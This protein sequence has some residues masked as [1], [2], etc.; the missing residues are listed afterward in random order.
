MRVSPEAAALARRSVVAKQHKKEGEH[1]EPVEEPEE[2]GAGTRAAHNRNV[3]MV[4]EEREAHG[5]NHGD[6]VAEAA[7][8]VM[9]RAFRGNEIHR[10]EDERGDAA[11]GVNPADDGNAS[12][13]HRILVT[14]FLFVLRYS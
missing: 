12:E 8:L 14:L 10:A 5:D 11:D 2:A 1:R 9:R 13:M 6:R 4:E 3:E 7:K